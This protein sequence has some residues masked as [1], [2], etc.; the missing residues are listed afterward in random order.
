MNF[1]DNER[2]FAKG[3]RGFLGTKCSL[4]IVIHDVE[5]LTSHNFAPPPN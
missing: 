2:I 4:D 1:L 5:V 3:V